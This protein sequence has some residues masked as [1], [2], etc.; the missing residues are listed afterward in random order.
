MHATSSEGAHGHSQGTQGVLYGGPESRL[1]SAARLSIG[2]RAADPG[3]LAR[4]E[5]QDRLPDA[6]SALQAG[7]LHD[8]AVR[9]RVP[10]RRSTSSRATSSSATMPTAKAA[11]SSVP[12]HTHAGRRALITAPSSR[13]PAACCW[14]CTISTRG[15]VAEWLASSLARR[16]AA[17][18]CG[19][20]ASRRLQ[21]GRRSAALR[22]G[23]AADSHEPRERPSSHE[24]AYA[25]RAS[26]AAKR[27]PT[28][29]PVRNEIGER[30]VGLRRH[31]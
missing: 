26:R 20:A 2:D 1:G 29:P 17:R 24:R 19:L 16:F 15:T 25:A 10:G 13:T 8:S 5:E 27:S 22:G 3:R 9:A 28:L 30:A 14:S 6:S 18:R 12:I 23:E 21:I 11:R 7:R 4:R 31:P